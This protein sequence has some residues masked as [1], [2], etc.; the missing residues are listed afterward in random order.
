MTIPGGAGSETSGSRQE[1][2]VQDDSDPGL[3]AATGSV[4]AGGPQTGEVQGGGA[5]A[6]AVRDQA[7]EGLGSAE[8]VD[9]D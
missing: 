9:D 5:V 8:N 2:T 1:T 7:P 6:D 3:P 4:A